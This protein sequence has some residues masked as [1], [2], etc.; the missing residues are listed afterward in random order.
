MVRMAKKLK[1]K[2]SQQ[3]RPHEKHSEEGKV[4]RSLLDSLSDCHV[5]AKD[6][7]SRFITTNAFH[8]KS[9]G[10]ASLQDVIGKTDF[11]F[12][13]RDLAQKYFDDEQ[14]V[15]RTGQAL[16]DQDERMLDAQGR[17]HWFLTSKMP[18]RDAEGRI[19]G[20]VGI[21][22]D[23]TARKRSENELAQQKEQL[24][25]IVETRV[26]QMRELA[27][28]LVQEVGERQIA[29]QKLQEEH[30]R[31]RVI[32]DNLS[33]CHL[34]IKDR[35]SRFVMTNAY[36]MKLLGIA[37]M[38][39]VAGKTDFD[40]F[41]REL[42]E[43][44]YI[45]EQSVMKTGQAIRNREE[46]CSDRT[47]N[48]LWLL[49]TKVP[50]KDA[51]GKVTGMVGMS[52]DIT[53]LKHASDALAEERNLL[54]TLIDALPMRI[55]IKDLDCRLLIANKMGLASA[56]L[57]DVIGKTDFDFFPREV[58]QQFYDE[59]QAFMKQGASTFRRLYASK[60]DKGEE[61]ILDVFKCPLRNSKGEVIGLVGI[62][63][64]VTELRKNEAALRTSQLQFERERN[65]LLALIDNIPHD[66]YA[67]DEAGRFIVANACLARTMRA[68]SAQELIG[69]TDFDFYPEK[70]ARQFRAEEEHILATGQ[71][72]LGKIE[73]KTDACGE[74]AWIITTKLPLRESDGRIVG[75]V[76]VGI[77]DTK[78]K[79]EEEKR[80]HL[81]KQLRH[82]DKMK[83]IGQLAGG[84]AHDFNNQLMTIM[85]SADLIRI[86]PEEGTAKH[87]AMILTAS[88]RAADLTG[89]LLAFARKG[90]YQSVSVDTHKMITEV[91]T[92][93]ERTIDKRI[94]IVT[95]L[96]AGHATVNGDPTQ[97]QNAL[98]NIAI[99]ARDAMPDEGEITFTTA[100]VMLDETFCRNHPHDLSPGSYILIGIA[101]TGAGMNEETKRHVFEPFFTTKPIGTGSG[102]GLAAV[103]GTVRNHQGSVAFT[104]ELGHGSEF[105]I[106]LPLAKS[107]DSKAIKKPEK[108]PVTGS[109]HILIAE[110]EEGIRRTLKAI[111][112]SLGY[113][114]TLC[115]DG[116]DAVDFYAK[117]WRDVDL[118]I[119]DMVM[120]R[121]GGLDAFLAMQ[122]INPPI[123]AILC[124]GYSRS[125]NSQ[126]IL[127]AG[128][129]RFIQKPFQIDALSNV[130]SEVLKD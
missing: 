49:T 97:L 126:K 61:S 121:M 129:K 54:R 1:G 113:R 57:D 112:L 77:N 119:V 127:N 40:F 91:V 106:W 62:N 105:R 86:S 47:G 118:V 25:G 122:A 46:P 124:S 34:F 98:L 71:P 120:P 53:E 104:S 7:A 125:G 92:L 42:A 41:P 76:G 44:Y 69:K 58:A 66:V 74:L 12:F 80:H 29:Q 81:E 52:L 114:V 48:R 85:G 110:D 107:P 33:S 11:D 23:I 88:Q 64:D 15:M 123:R 111:L 27:G 26:A 72:L 31:L 128:V 70:Q 108:A 13:P 3:V 24:E 90:R 63:T 55:F 14:Q 21:S 20:L 5:F 32:M 4:L 67:K 6:T 100:P 115:N 8:L 102:M 16:V 79:L 83:A 56:R 10:A 96:G 117:S 75:I 9:L 18:L 116:Q 130:I 89:K 30:D 28:R 93:L 87:V 99:N 2:M 65:L 45:D 84:I 50:I 36:Q 82:A 38:D 35:E 68:G 95:R 22:N 17:E 51:T 37:S 78:R 19:T 59:E 109:A 94:R 103:Y 73:P 39:L 60:N 43:Q 101:D